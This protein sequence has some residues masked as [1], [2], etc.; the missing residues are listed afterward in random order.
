MVWQLCI[1]YPNGKERTLRSYRNRESALK[2]IDA[3][4][5]LGYPMHVAYVVRPV[6][7]S[8]TKALNDFRAQ[9]IG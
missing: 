4:Y 5:A 2:Q 1:R 8:S 7:L 9:A 3:I 6:E